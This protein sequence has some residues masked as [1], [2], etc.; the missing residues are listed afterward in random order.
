MWLLL[1]DICWIG[2]IQSSY[3]LLN[4][5]DHIYT[6]WIFS[7]FFSP[8]TQRNWRA[9]MMRN[10]VCSHSKMMQWTPWSVLYSRVNTPP[11]CFIYRCCFTCQTKQQWQMHRT[12]C[13]MPESQRIRHSDTGAKRQDVFFFLFFFPFAIFCIAL[14]VLHASN[15]AP[16]ISQ[17]WY[18]R[19]PN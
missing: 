11:L 5:S 14:S 10:H 4:L 18:H 1:I 16:T 19:N 2:V 7:F 12:K 6:K 17:P 3:A 8:P 13:W 9:A 15:P